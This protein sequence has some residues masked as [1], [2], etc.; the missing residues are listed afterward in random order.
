[1][2]IEQNDPT[3]YVDVPNETW[4]KEQ[5]DYAKKKGPNKW[6]VPFM[7]KITAYWK[8]GAVYMPV[9]ILS[10]LKGQRDEQ[11]NV[12]KD[13][14]EWLRQ[15]LSEN[16]L[17][18]V[19]VPYIEVGYDGQPWVSEGNH[20]IMVAAEMEMKTIQVEV[21]YFDGGERIVDGPL[22][23]DRIRALQGWCQEEHTTNQFSKSSPGRPWKN[24]DVA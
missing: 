6:G 20:R 9:T 17:T 3:L 15:E 24:R 13:S 16:G 8:D 7:G 10:R 1:M 19:G 4:L 18:K 23:P 21:R 2:H 22:Y 12:R 14:L 5:I 11:N